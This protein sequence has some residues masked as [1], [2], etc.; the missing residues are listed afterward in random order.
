MSITPKEGDTFTCQCGNGQVVSVYQASQHTDE[1]TC[2]C[3]TKY[4]HG[5]GGMHR[6]NNTPPTQLPPTERVYYHL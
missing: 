1:I 5:P 3:G 2:Q 6:I 4:L